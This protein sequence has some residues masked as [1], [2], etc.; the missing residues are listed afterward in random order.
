MFAYIVRRVVVGIVMLI[1]MSMLTFV[2]FF[3]SGVDVARYACGKSCTQAQIAQ[4]RVALGYQKPVPE[5]WWD[6]AKGFVVGRDFPDDAAMRKAAPQN[7]VTCPPGCLG[8]SYF[9]TDTV[10]DLLKQAWPISFS[11]ALVAFLMWIIGGV[12]FGVIAA[13]KR[14]TLLD[15]S[16]VGV[17]LLFYAFPTF[18]IGYLLLFFPAIKWHIVPVPSWI[19]LTQ[20][21]WQWFVNLLLPG[22]TLA[23]FYMAGYVRM[24]R[25]FVLESRGEDY[26]RTAV[27]KGVT[28]FWVV[29]KH[30]LRAA[31]SPLLTMAGIDLAVLLGGA[32]ITETVFNFPG[33]GLTALK[34]VQQFDLPT[35]LGIVLLL[36]AFVIVANII[37]DVLYAVIDPRVRLK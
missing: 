29:V 6:F 13:L 36:S 24:T 7:V 22:L 25:A 5:L 32:I 1:A 12:V 23:L 26:M 15:R 4:T 27:A 37:V 10:G 31:L 34:A 14:G 35:T 28:P 33:L 21:P 8:Y 2:L 17:T 18:F 30:N 16:I 11:I 20:D 3:A 19:P 9:S